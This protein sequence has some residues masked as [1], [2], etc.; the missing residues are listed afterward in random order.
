MIKKLVSIIIPV[1]NAEK[2]IND[3]IKSI[4]NQTYP[5]YEV[6]LVDDGSK[7]CS[8]EILKKYENNEKVKIL[9]SDNYGAPHARNWG[10][11]IAQGEYVVF[12]DSDDIMEENLL[13]NLVNGIEDNNSDMAIG[14]YVEIDESGIIINKENLPLKQGVYNTLEKESLSA[15]MR[16]IPFPDNKIYR[17]DII[18]KYNINF[19]DIKIGQDLNFY[20][21]YLMMCRNIYITE[22]EVCRYRLVKGSISHSANSKVLDIILSID[23][24]ERFANIN[25]NTDIFRRE[26]NN[27]RVLHY[28]IQLGKY[29]FVADK[30]ERKKI[31]NT[32]Y[33]KLISIEK[34][35]NEHLS[36]ESK[37]RI[38]IIK[39]K[40]KLKILSMNPIYLY[41]YR[42]SHKSIMGG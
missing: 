1:Y 8:L 21:K 38:K 40:Q 32:F 11:S 15:L 7:D 27:I 19:A 37:Q 9:A 42:K 29:P 26:I 31:F 33:T 30:K 25:N 2:Y 23:D 6:I 14:S 34:K 16:L 28:S 20:L 41:Y 36:K 22:I 4:L 35:Y 17:M 24:I 10:L 39:L 18:N 13:K 12:F 5:Y 3:T